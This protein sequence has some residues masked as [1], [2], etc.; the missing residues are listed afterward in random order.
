MDIKIVPPITAGM[1]TKLPK[2]IATINASFIG[3]SPV[4]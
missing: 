4:E 1:R 3:P 2:T